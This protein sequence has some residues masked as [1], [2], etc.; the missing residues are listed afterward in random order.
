[1]QSAHVFKEYADKYLEEEEEVESIDA[2][3][4][5][6]MPYAFRG[7]LILLLNDMLDEEEHLDDTAVI[8]S[9]MALFI[10]CYKDSSSHLERY[11]M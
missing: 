10:N 2:K 8:V 7:L 4:Q 11:L 1:M 6:V 9:Q 5:L 3:Y